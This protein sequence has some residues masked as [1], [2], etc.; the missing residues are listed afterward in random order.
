MIINF[1]FSPL[2]EKPPW[3]MEMAILDGC[4]WELSV[5]IS[6]ESMGNLLTLVDD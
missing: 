1:Q 2:R 3:I 5:E 6:F 4:N